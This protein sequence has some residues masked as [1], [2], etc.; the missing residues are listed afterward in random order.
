MPGGIVAIRLH[1]VRL[2]RD[3]AVAGS[4][5]VNSAVTPSVVRGLADVPDFD[6]R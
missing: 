5:I 6:S 3:F 4:S 2:N 1:R